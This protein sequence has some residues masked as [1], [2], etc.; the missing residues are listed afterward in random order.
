MNVKNNGGESPWSMATGLS[1]SSMSTYAT[2]PETAALLVRLGATVLTPQEL[3]IVKRDGFRALNRVPAV[4][5]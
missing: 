4:A 5:R 2:H 3:E 1:P